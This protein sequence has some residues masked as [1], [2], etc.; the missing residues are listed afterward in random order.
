MPATR[1]IHVRDAL[2]AL[3]TM[4]LGAC[5]ALHPEQ[6]APPSSARPWSPPE[7]PAYAAALAEGERARKAETVTVDPAKSY[8]LSE[9]IDIAQRTNPETRVA[10]ERA[11]QAAIG[12]GLAEGTYYP[13]LAVVARAAVAHVPIQPRSFPA[14]FQ[15]DTHFVIPVLQLEWL[16]LDFGRR[17]ALVDAARALTME[18]TAGFNAK[19]QQIVF[20]VT[21]D[22]HALTAVR[23][24]VAANQAAVAAAKSL[25]EAAEVRKQN[26]LATLPEI[27]QAQEETAS[28]IYDLQD[29][30][31][32]EH[33]ARMALLET[34]GIRP[35]T[36]IQIADVSQQPL[37]HALA[38]SVDEAIDRAL[39]QCPDLIA[40]LAAVR[41]KEAE[42]RRARADYWPRLAAR[43]A[44]GGNIGEL[45]VEDS[46]FQSVEDL[47][48]DAGLR[49]EWSLFEGFERR[50]KVRLAES[51]Q[52]EAESELEQ[53]KDKAV[54]EVWKAYDDTKVALV[55]DAAT[56]ARRVGEGLSRDARLLPEPL[57]TFPDVRT[58][59]QPGPRAAVP[60][61]AC[62]G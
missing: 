41:A 36:P 22:F 47:Q 28:A 23:G 50:N 14:V 57:A 29:A 31:A 9:L 5:A 27:L 48:Y 32:A 2:L 21:R 40:R 12:M 51:M 59:A 16:V 3:W 15:A 6:H 38:E 39:T 34:I 11:R 61:S 26:G 33:D 35:G 54:R 24:K 8:E 37:P 43:A 49:F 44:V 17:Q 52:Q 42:V 30:I 7:L 20:E 18:A 25:G 45:K 56:A 1:G 60:G 55:N 53:A 46:A 10:W 4:V 62:R 58:Q 13:A 19:H